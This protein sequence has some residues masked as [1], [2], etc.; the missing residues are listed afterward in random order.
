MGRFQKCYHKKDQSQRYIPL[1]R[2]SAVPEKIDD[3]PEFTMFG[4]LPSYGLYGRHVR[5]LILNNV[6][7]RLK[8]SDFRPKYV[9]DDV[10]GLTENNRNAIYEKDAF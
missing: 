9:F 5:G 7:F 1:S 3:Y 6:N 10:E 4:E 8:D 2:L